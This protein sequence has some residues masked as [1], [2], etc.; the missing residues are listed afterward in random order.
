MRFLIFVLCAASAA[1]AQKS[2]TEPVAVRYHLTARPWSALNTPAS[3]YLDVIE[4]L[5]RFSIQHQVASGAIIDPFVHYE[6]QYATPYFAHAAGT[7]FAAGRARD[8]LPNGIRAMEHST[9]QFAQGK[10]VIPQE[11]GEFFI[12]A[13]TQAVELYRPFVSK[14]QW[15]EWR[16]RMANPVGNV[17]KSNFNNWETYPMKGEW[18]R[19]KAGLV[20]RDS[21]VAFIEKAW[22]EHQRARIAAE[23]FL[24]YHDRTS[25]PDTLS[26]EAVGRGNL[27][28]LI[29]SGYD[30]PSAA[31]ISR[32]VEHAT[33]VTLLLQDPSGQVPANGRTDDHVWVDVG[34]QLGFEVMAERARAAGDL[35]SAGRFRRAALLAFQSIQRWR[36]SDGKWAGSFFVTKNHFDPTLRVGHQDAS[37]YSNYNGSLM[38]HMAE[39]YHL[40]KSEIAEQ[41]APAEIGGYSFAL[42]REFSAA[43]ANAGGMQVEANL[44]GQTTKTHGNFW[45]PLGIVRLARAGWDTRLGPADGALTEQGGVSFAPEFEENGR[46]LRMASLSARYEGVWNVEFAHPALVRCNLEYRPKAGQTGPAFR[47]DLV[48]TPDGVFAELRKT[49]TDALAWGVT[50]PLLEN[51]GRPLQRSGTRLIAETGFEK[52]GDRQ[53][54]LALD[55]SSKIDLGVDPLRSTFGDLRPVR[56]TVPGDRNRTFV[57]PHT[58]DQPG[59]EAVRSSFRTTNDGFQ[60]ALGRVTGRVYVGRTVAGGEGSGVDVNGRGKPDVTFSE[61]CGFLLQLKNG[62]VIAAET[63]RRVKAT[64]QGKAV[65]LMPFQPLR[66]DS[67]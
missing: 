67:R 27:L 7:L 59:A 34:Y 23:P 12:P 57:Y 14:E 1:T 41:P 54:Y 13:L 31:E 18:L 65:E 50:W 22:S 45:T 10:S 2:S 11:H 30:G 55:A 52:V 51:D 46:W 48:I 6:H 43:F 28:A 19:Y 17:I 3:Q 29:H 53:S 25:D 66:L 42:D 61:R 35:E 58:Q 20:S 47:H 26:V 9:A 49:S 40:R 16:K 36:R 24:L 37:Q 21:A 4:G 63:D 39:A 38:F 56:V 5:C 8:I 15:S 32:I 44:R 60:S 33:R 62:K 64:I